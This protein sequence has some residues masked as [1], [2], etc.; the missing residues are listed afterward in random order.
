M[1]IHNFLIFLIIFIIS[2]KIKI[3]FKKIK[4]KITKYLI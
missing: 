1:D 2:K 3:I 4:K